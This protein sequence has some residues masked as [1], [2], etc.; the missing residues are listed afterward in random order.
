MDAV[1]H[2]TRVSLLSYIRPHHD[3]NPHMSHDI[4]TQSIRQLGQRYET[5]SL[6]IVGLRLYR[7]SNPK[8][9]HVLLYIF[10]GSETENN[11]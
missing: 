6:Y 10:H 7:L 2:T 5:P 11:R 4:M 3:N 1:F 9:L 8:S